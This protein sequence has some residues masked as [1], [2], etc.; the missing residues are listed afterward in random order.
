VTL[1]AKHFFF[2]V[3]P[4]NIILTTFKKAEDSNGLILRFYEWAGKDTQVKI[5]LPHGATSQSQPI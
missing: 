3:K 4:C 1:P 5:Y 2:C